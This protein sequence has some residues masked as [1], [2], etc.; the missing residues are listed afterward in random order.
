MRDTKMLIEH[1]IRT[2]DARDLTT[3]EL[4]HLATG[5]TGV[6]THFVRATPE[7][8]VPLLKEL[9]ARL[10]DEERTVLHRWLEGPCW[11]A[12]Q[13]DDQVMSAAA[14]LKVA[15]E[16]GRT[17][18]DAIRHAIADFVRGLIDPEG[19]AADVGNLRRR[20]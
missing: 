1:V 11:E 19:V 6:R 2:R 17:P 4:T 20:N 3:E 7:L 15:V 12:L 18:V 8:V 14:V 16:K 13:D 10:A 5:H 9:T